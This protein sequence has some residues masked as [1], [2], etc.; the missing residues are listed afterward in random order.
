MAQPPPQAPAQFTPPPRQKPASMATYKRMLRKEIRK[1]AVEP[2]IDFL[3]ITAMLDMMTIIL[4]F[5]LKSM[6]ASSASIP[7]GD[8]L[9]MPKSVLT[10]EA[11]QEGLTIIISKTHI[12][13]DDNSVC[14]VPHDATHGVEAKYKQTGTTNDLYIVPLANAAQTWRDRDRAMKSA[15]GM[16]STTEAILIADADTP[17]RLITEVMFTLGRVEVAGAGIGKFHL[18]VM[19]G[20]KK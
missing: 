2:E 18:M 4:V 6:A 11:S 12:I 15:M 17:F 3:N 20:S 19:Q 9:K 16:D 14:P 5:L 13:V 10:T 8:D 7:Q 1:N